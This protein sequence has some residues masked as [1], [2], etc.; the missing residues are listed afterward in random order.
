MGAHEGQ[1]W[2]TVEHPTHL[3]YQSLIKDLMLESEYLGA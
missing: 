1:I 2:R 3:E